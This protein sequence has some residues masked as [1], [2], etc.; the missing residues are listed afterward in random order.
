MKIET[1]RLIL[2]HFK[3]S[4]GASLYKYAQNPKIGPQA[5]WPAHKSVEESEA[6]IENGLTGELIFA[7]TLKRKPNEV[8]GCIDLNINKRDFMTARE[9]EIGY[10][11]GEPFWGQGLIPEAVKA[12][13]SFGFDMCHLKVIWC[14]ASTTNINSQRV[15]E[16]VGFNY[17]KTLKNIDYP[18]L[19]TSEDLRMS[20]IKKHDWQEKG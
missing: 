10:W 4:D 2:R 12:L 16:K 3:E 17:V 5:G 7:I 8:I 13:V 18:L 15:Q 6:I 20:C 19:H 9:A 11:I 14:A 1:D